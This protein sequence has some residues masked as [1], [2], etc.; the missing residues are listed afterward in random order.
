MP[1]NDV[2][3]SGQT[4]GAT[5]N[6]IR[7]N[8]LTIEDSFIVDHVDYGASGEGKHNKVTFPVQASA[9][10]FLSGEEGLYNLLNATTDVNELYIHK[11]TS[12]GTAEIPFTASILSESAPTSLMPGWTYLPSGI[13]VR[14]D[15]IIGNA[16]MNTTTLGG[17]GFPVFNTLYTVFLTPYSATA[18]DVNFAVRLVGIVSNTQFTTYFS[19]RTSSGGA[20]GSAWALSIGS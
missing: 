10:S 14:W 5:Q 20:A 13:L 17:A 18:G 8:F 15:L 16:G 4:L 12:A 9:P 2:P 7:Q 11:Q 6:P 3:L 19:S 1:L